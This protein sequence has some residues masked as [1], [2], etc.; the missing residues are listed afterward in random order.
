MPETKTK[1]KVGRPSKYQPSINEIILKNMAEGASLEELCLYNIDLTT[2]TI[3]DWIDEDSPRYNK[4]FSVTIK[5]GI[6]LA[7]AWWLAQGRCL[8]DKDINC[9][10]WYM[11]MKNRFQWKD[12]QE[13]S[14]VVEH[15]HRHFFQVMIA[16]SEALDDFGN[17]VKNRIADALE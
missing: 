5:K 1:K 11:N 6:V 12:K 17:P 10:L 16:K 9:A 8:R 4:E 2:E 7:K 15:E 14:G 13:F 3:R